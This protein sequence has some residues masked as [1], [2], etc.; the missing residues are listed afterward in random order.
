MTTGTWHVGPALLERYADGALDPSAQASVETHLASCAQCQHHAS[1]LVASPELNAIW[2]DVVAEIV[3]PPM[4][5][6][7]RLLRRLGLPDADTVVLRASSE[8]LYRPWLVSVVGALIFGVLAGM[9]DARLQLVSIMLLAPL[10]PVLAV[11]L[12]YD[13]TDQMRE[14]AMAK[15]L[16]KLR[17]ALLRAGAAAGVAIPLTLA[18]SV[19][20]PGIADHAFVWLLPAVTLTFLAVTLLTWCTA[21]VTGGVIATAWV[22]F[23]IAI[24]ADDS[25][26]AITSPQGQLAFVVAAFVAVGVL[27]VRITSPRSFGG[28]A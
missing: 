10:L 6:G 12:A 11:T 20:I 21:K 7:L 3:Q 2:D 19:T 22:A 13:T 18:V 25:L 24:R 15:P 27:V 9:L 17:I 26:G 5:V 4:P 28:Y 16:S 14:L 23:I 8:G 1:A